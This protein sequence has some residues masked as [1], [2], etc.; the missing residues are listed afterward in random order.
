[1]PALQHSWSASGPATR[2]SPGLDMP[3]WKK[4]QP[5]AGV[6]PQRLRIA[7]PDRTA[8]AYRGFL[9][10]QRG[11]PGYPELSADTG[12]GASSRHSRF[13]R[14][15][16]TL[17]G[18]TCSAGA[19]PLPIRGAAASVQGL[20]LLAEAAK[21]LKAQGL[22]SSSTSWARP[23]VIPMRSNQSSSTRGKAQDCCDIAARQTM[24]CPSFRRAACWFFRRRCGKAFRVPFSRPVLRAR[25]HHHRCAGVRRDD[26]TRCFRLR[27]PAR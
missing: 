19:R 8:Q 7:A 1:M 5:D 2:C 15:H 22:D 9:L 27:R 6:C 23:T 12:P 21:L 18:D 20:A 4:I 24:S 3:S 10:Q 25:C 14:R 26:R 13:R 11:P 16:R 17:F